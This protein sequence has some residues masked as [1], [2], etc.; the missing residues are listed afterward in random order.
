MILVTGG[1]G[2]VGSH[3]LYALINQ[4]ESVRAIHRKTSNLNAVRKVFAFY[5]KNY[6]VL[7]DKIEWIDGNITNIPSLTKAFD[8]VDYVYHCAAFISFN[9]KHFEV[10]EK[11]NIEGTA[12]VVNLCLEKGV[13]KLCY[14]SSIATLG[15]TT[16]NTFITEKTEYNPDN[17]NSVYAITKY[18][19]E[20]EVWR[21]TQE[22]LKAV[23]VQP[24]VILGSGIWK[25]ASGSIFRSVSKGVPFYTSGGV[26]VVDVRDVVKAMITLM[27]STIYNDNFILVSVN[28]SYKKLL[29]SVAHYLG[30][31]PPRKKVKKGLLLAYSNL[32]WLS[33]KLFKTKRKL[34]KGMIPSLF[35]T[36]TYSSK[37]IEKE[38]DF[39]FTPFEET[40]KRVC[41]NYL[42]ES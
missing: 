13:K 40:V 19:A 39:K 17:N 5:T 14:I 9:T 15:K 25:S 24:G 41:D 6:E 23:I 18:G 35:E 21:A 7:F 30:K 27:K 10:L 20:M 42:I 38:L 8:E 26:G 34:L 22:G 29:H 3:L 36:A 4:G 33:N 32:D 31:K 11:V 16:N 28:I 1:T 12:N 37:K 2:Q